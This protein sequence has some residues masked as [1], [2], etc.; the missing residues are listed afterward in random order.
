M[1]TSN[2][3]KWLVPSLLGLPG[4][5]PQAG[6]SPDLGQASRSLSPCPVQIPA[7]LL[8]LWRAWMG[9]ECRVWMVE[10]FCQWKLQASWAAYL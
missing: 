7:I 10:G 8:S 9:A 4:A 3:L 2:L 1:L 6:A 5:L